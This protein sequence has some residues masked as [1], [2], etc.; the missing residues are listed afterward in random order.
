MHT[1][2]KSF[3]ERNPLIIGA[4]GAALVAVLVLG[5]LNYQKLPILNQTK[6]YSAYF[7]DA[8]GLFTGAGVQVSGYPA[9]KVSSIS[10]DG[11]QVLVTFTVDDSVRM[12]EDSE[13]AIKTKSLLGTKVLDV[14][15]R[16]GG[17]LNGPIPLSRTVSPYQLPDALA[18]LAKTISGL[19]TNQLSGS[20]STLSDTFADTPDELRN[21]VQE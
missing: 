9:G 5:A 21:A 14:T 6:S 15:P 20:L 4:I 12:G 17:S 16:G 19:D 10:L 13:A 8:G 11:A 1:E 3:S 18:D 7:A 2:V